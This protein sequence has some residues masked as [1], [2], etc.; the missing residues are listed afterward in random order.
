MDIGDEVKRAMDAAV[1]ERSVVTLL[2][3]GRTGVGKSTLVNAVFSGNLAETGHGRPVTKDTREYTKE[4]LPLCILDTRGMETA[5][6][7]QSLRELKNVL[8]DRNGDPKV[9]RH[10]H[11]AW[12]CVAE[13]SRRVEDAETE[14][15]NV[16]A[17]HTSVVGVVTKA[18]ADQGFRAEVQRLLPDAKNVVR[19]RAIREELDDGHVLEPEGLVKLVELTM[20]LVPESQRRAFV[21][22]Q[23]ASIDL[24]KRHAR[25]LITAAVATAGAAGAAPIPFSDAALLVPIQ[26]G[27][28]AGI[29][30]TFGITLTAAFLS[31]L[32]ASMAGATGATLVGRALVG[33]LLKL[34]PG[35]G[36]LVGGVISGATAM[37]LTGALGEVYV[38]TLAVVYGRTNGQTPTAA[39]VQEEFSAQL[40][41]K[42][43]K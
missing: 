32:V 12:I 33:G 19:V 36:S 38:Q 13:D 21:A 43:E 20:T 26:I 27:M 16:L 39:E 1:R 34:L 37:A 8:R 22:A 25:G 35:A 42:L 24:K 4:G 2:M 28:L 14:T 30:A 10:I 15:C 7:D 9:D 18:R 29:S 11:A 6:Y 23:R 41:A 5:A 3:A 17:K 31:T 40:A